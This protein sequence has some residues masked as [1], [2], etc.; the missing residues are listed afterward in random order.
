M[1]KNKKTVKKSVFDGD[2]ELWTDRDFVLSGEVGPF[3]QQLAL[4]QGQDAGSLSNQHRV[5]QAA[6]TRRRWD[7]VTTLNTQEGESQEQNA[8][9]L[10]KPYFNWDI[11][12]RRTYLRLLSLLLSYKLR[13]NTQFGPAVLFELTFTC[14]PSFWW[15][16][17]PLWRHF[18]AWNENEFPDWWSV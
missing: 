5:V 15:T 7:Q 13:E 17:R 11:C 3:A 1:K 18:V 16:I 4:R 9:R 12:E 14:K 6:V 2:R 10:S 8:A